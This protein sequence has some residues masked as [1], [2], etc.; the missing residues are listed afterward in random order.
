M[1]F[2]RDEG[3][4]SASLLTPRSTLFPF[5]TSRSRIGIRCRTPTGV[6][7]ARFCTFSCSTVSSA[8]AGP[9]LES[10]IYGRIWRRRKARRCHSTTFRGH[11]GSPPQFGLR[12]RRG[13]SGAAGRGSPWESN[14][15][16]SS[17][18]TSA[19]H[20]AIDDCSWGGS[21]AGSALSTA[22]FSS[23]SGGRASPNK[24]NHRCQRRTVLP[25][26]IRQPAIVWTG[27][28]PRR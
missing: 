4:V 7:S 9:M 25:L 3:L 2:A 26:S 24:Q 11:R 17:S 10:A 22:A 8:M 23:S 14:P 12:T 6:R 13:A 1:N 18:L 28:T 27:S 5:T 16:S 21:T 19:C 20:F 15:F